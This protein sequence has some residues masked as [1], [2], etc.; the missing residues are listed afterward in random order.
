MHGLE[1]ANLRELTAKLEKDVAKEQK[2]RQWTIEDVKAD[3]GRNKQLQEL[4]NRWESSEEMTR[5][6]GDTS[7]AALV[8]CIVNM[9]HVPTG[10]PSFPVEVQPFV[11]V[12]EIADLMGICRRPWRFYVMV[13]TFG[14]VKSP[15][16]TSL[17]RGSLATGY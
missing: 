10:M 2:L 8:R 14:A 12:G 15:G 17:R 5:G 11:S 4:E 9:R 6:N 13:P 3:L 1:I 7:D 16:E